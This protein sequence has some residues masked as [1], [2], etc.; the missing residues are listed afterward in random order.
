M[1]LMVTNLVNGHKS[2][3]QLLPMKIFF[4]NICWPQ[5]CTNGFWTRLLWGEWV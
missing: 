4:G 3:T 5:S 1:M 2:G